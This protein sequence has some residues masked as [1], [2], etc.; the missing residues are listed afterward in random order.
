MKRT[1]TQNR[2]LY[3]L[4]NELGIS[5]DIRAGLASDFSGG[6]T[7]K[8][9][10]LTI[11]ECNN[12]IGSLNAEKQRRKQSAD[13]RTQRLRRSLIACIYD[14]PEKLKFWHTD[15][16][17]KRFDAK[18]FDEFLQNSKKSPFPGK[19]LNDLKLNEINKLIAIMK[20]WTVFYNKK[21]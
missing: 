7:E 6:R 8:T 3:G 17:R 18:A 5:A 1:A 16:E 9:S 11:D 12:L 21:K 15:G 10:E 20:K 2:R 19:K 14:L 13:Q 4:L